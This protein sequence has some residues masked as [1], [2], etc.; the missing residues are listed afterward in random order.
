MQVLFHG[1]VQEYTA[2]ETSFEPSFET[3]LKASFEPALE[4]TGVGTVHGLIDL[5]GTRYGKP[6]RDFVHEVESCV[7]L[8]NG[9]G[10]MLT[11]GMATAIQEGDTV[12]I[13]PFVG[14]G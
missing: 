5:L 6:F 10:I 4:T 11:G 14:A 9:R 8:V 7:I 12:T 13:L 2:G 1:A 3:S